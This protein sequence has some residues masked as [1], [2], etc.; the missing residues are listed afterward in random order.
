[1]T[2]MSGNWLEYK[3][4]KCN[5]IGVLLQTPD[6]EGH[7][8]GQIAVFRRSLILRHIS[9][10]HRDPSEPPEFSTAMVFKYHSLTHFQT[11]FLSN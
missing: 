1:M 9:G 3:V 6:K 8:D 11:H 7:K 2:L 4:S 5:L 10:T